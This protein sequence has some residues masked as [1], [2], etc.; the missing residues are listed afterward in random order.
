MLAS[1]LAPTGF[2]S[3]RHYPGLQG[4]AFAAQ[5]GTGLCQQACELGGVSASAAR[6]LFATDAGVGAVNDCQAQFAVTVLC[7]PG[8]ALKRF[9][10]VAGNQKGFVETERGVLRVV[11]L[12][13]PS[14]D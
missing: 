7:S 14:S 12:V 11:S 6:D 3:G 8:N 10:G 1:K 2:G 9:K 13:C 4:V 5:F